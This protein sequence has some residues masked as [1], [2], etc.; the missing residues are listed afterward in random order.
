MQFLDAISVHPLGS[1]L[2]LNK[3]HMPRFSLLIY[4]HFHASTNP[5]TTHLCTCN[6][7]HCLRHEPLF[8]TIQ[9]CLNNIADLQIYSARSRHLVFQHISF[10]FSL[11]SQTTIHS[12]QCPLPSAFHC[13][14][15]RSSDS[16]PASIVPGLVWID[17]LARVVLWKMLHLSTNQTQDPN[18]QP[19][20]QTLTLL[21]QSDSLFPLCYH[22]YQVHF[23]AHAFLQAAQNTGQLQNAFWSST[24]SRRQTLPPFIFSN[25]LQ[26]LTT[27]IVAHLI[28]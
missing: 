1:F 23:T 3:P 2:E 14:F 16:F 25:R 15:T 27:N 24:I 17:D 4:S 5:S 9:S 18:S 8:E 7:K 21:L 22:Y 6:T 20:P 28:F 19:A 13:N 12:L 11:S 26:Q 10:I